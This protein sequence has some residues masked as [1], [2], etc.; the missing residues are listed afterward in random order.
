MTTVDG[1]QL[2]KIPHMYHVD[3]N[4]GSM[5]INILWTPMIQ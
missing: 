5:V 4:M 1:V 3:A 2:L